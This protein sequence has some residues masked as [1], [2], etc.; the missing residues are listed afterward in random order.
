MCVLLKVSCMLETD[1]WRSTV[2]LCLDWNQNRS[3][4][5]WFILTH[6]HLQ[7]I[8][9]ENECWIKK[10]WDES[11]WICYVQFIVVFLHFRSQAHSQGTIMFKVVPITDRPVNNQTMVSHQ[12]SSWERFITVTK[13][14]KRSNHI[15]YTIYV[16]LLRFR[17]HCLEY[18]F[19]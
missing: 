9:I 13:E 8:N 18:C 11:R 19:F 4:K 1:W 12:T 16:T 5:F 2:I 14:R 15:Y 17:A 7:Y 3:Y 10:L 6:T